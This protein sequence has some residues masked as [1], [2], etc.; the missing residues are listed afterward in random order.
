LY[1]D[2]WATRSDVVDSVHVIQ[3]LYAASRVEHRQLAAE[4]LSF[5]FRAV[6]PTTGERMGLYEE[7]SY[8]LAREA[9]VAS[10]K[11]AD[12]PASAVSD[13]IVVSCTG[14]SAPGL[15]ILLARDLGMPPNVRRLVVGHMG[16]YGALVG[17]RSALA[18]LRA[19]PNALV[20]LT[21]VEI[22]SLH[23]HAGGGRLD[24]GSLTST[25][26]FGDAAAS[27]VLKACGD[28]TGPELVDVYCAAD[29]KTSDQMSWKI[30]D[31]G[32]VMGLSSR[33]PITLRRNVAGV[34][35]RLLATH[36]LTASEISHWLVH[37]GGPD[38]LD[39]VA[40]ALELSQEQMAISWEVLR[41]HGNCS[42]STV[43]LMLNRLLRSEQTRPGEWGVMM[44]FGPGL[45]LETCL[46]RF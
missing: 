10:L 41:D 44:A 43:L 9:L 36:A 8:P 28:S 35:D 5:Y 37:P 14:Y 33:I 6:P 32:F 23:F 11:R 20:A 1:G 45:T 34:V 17:L 15:D 27:V 21:T 18:T 12:Y 26:L 40:S 42:S 22:C 46:F 16:C 19:H 38:I 2:N 4:L 7:L 24:P 31:E 29:F 25:A 39:G 30:T 3:R 13:F